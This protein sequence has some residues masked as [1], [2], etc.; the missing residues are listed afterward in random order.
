MVTKPLIV[1]SLFLL[2]VMV[3]S[4]EANIRNYRSNANG[5]V[6]RK[7]I[8]NRINNETIYQKH[9]LLRSA[10]YSTNRS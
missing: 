4:T 8:G 1:L 7:D 6:E 10:E 9:H 2:I 5:M 3:N